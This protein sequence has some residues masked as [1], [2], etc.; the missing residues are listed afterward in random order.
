MYLHLRNPF[1]S[2]LYAYSES[3]VVEM[4]QLESMFQHFSRYLMSWVTAEYLVKILTYLDIAF[5]PET[6][7]IL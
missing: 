1:L 2:Y 7:S 3:I 4:I 5:E 6:E